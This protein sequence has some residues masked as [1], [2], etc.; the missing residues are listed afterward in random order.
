MFACKDSNLEDVGFFV[1]SNGDWR[2]RPVKVVRE[3]M[4]LLDKVHG[5]KPSTEP[6]LETRKVDRWTRRREKGWPISVQSES[7]LHEHFRRWGRGKDASRVK[8]W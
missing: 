3:S 5:R 4:T 6:V 2:S 7:R 1:R 8:E